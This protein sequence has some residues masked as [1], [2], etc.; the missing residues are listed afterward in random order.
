[1]TQITSIVNKRSRS[2]NNQAAQ[3]SNLKVDQAKNTE[4]NDNYQSLAG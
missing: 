4:P 2:I 1:M 3:S